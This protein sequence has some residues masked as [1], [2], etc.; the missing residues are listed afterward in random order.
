MGWRKYLKYP[1]QFLLAAGLCGDFHTL[2]KQKAVLSAAGSLAKQRGDTGM[3]GRKQGQGKVGE[4]LLLFIVQTTE[5]STNT[6]E[7]TLIT[8]NKAKSKTRMDSHWLEL[9]I[10]KQQI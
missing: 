4:Q 5:I 1:L 10:P 9:E 3:C 8:K 7:K 6:E 2:F